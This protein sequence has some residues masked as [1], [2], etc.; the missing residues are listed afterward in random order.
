MSPIKKS[1][2]GN[3]LLLAVA[4]IFSLILGEGVLRFSTDHP[5]TRESNQISD[6]ILGYRVNPEFEDIDK[7]GFR[8]SEDIR[9]L[10]AAIGDSHTYG[11]NVSSEGSWPRQFSKLAG[12]QTYNFGIGSYGVY[13]YHPL[14]QRAA[15]S[16]MKAVIV[17]V[18]P[19][20][21]FAPVFS[22]C[23][24]NR[25][26]QFWTQEAARLQLNFPPCNNVPTEESFTESIKNFIYYETA[27]GSILI[28][29]IRRI[30]SRRLDAPIEGTNEIVTPWNLNAFKKHMDLG[31]PAISYLLEDFGRFIKDWVKISASEDVVVSLLIIP[32][33][34]LSLSKYAETK[35]IKQV[36]REII[37]AIEK[38]QLIVKMILDAAERYGLP[39]T[40]AL[41]EVVEAKQNLISEFL[42]HRDGHPKAEGY[43]AYAKAA[44]RLLRETCLSDHTKE[45]CTYLPSQ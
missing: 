26:S 9:P 24:I 7:N 42:Y 38:E 2:L 45:I 22:Y 21:D 5:I 12:L 44:L 33:K 30:K 28:S 39:A 34:Q 27:I 29:N 11:S 36:S 3:L 32:S 25:D 1:M 20:N 18:Y 4:S 37:S 35:G 14:V 19:P 31:N 15:E 40:S 13:S 10:I 16:E 17:A 43:A 6:E 41:P 8:N 23:K